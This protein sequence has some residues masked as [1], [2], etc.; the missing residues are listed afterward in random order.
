MPADLVLIAIGFEGPEVTC[1]NDDRL[2]LGDSGAIKTND[3]KMTDIEGVF[4]AGDAS[5]GQSIVVWAI[6]EGRDVA[7]QIDIYL[8]GNSKL[9]PS[10]QTPNPPSPARGL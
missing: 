10:L 3:R 1:L 8:T 2:T 5:R 7:R 4:A 9:P 6:G